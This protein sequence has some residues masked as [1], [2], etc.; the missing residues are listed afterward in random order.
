MTPMESQAAY[1]KFRHA[2][3]YARKILVEKE[4]WFGNPALFNDPFDCSIDF[5]HFVERNR[6][7]FNNPEEIIKFVKDGLHVNQEQENRYI[8]SLNSYRDPAGCYPYEDVVMWSHYGDDH[9]GVCFGFNFK[10]LRSNHNIRRNDVHYDL[11]LFL[12]DLKQ[13]DQQ[14]TDI[15]QTNL[16]PYIQDFKYQLLDYQYFLKA[17][18]W[19]YEQECRYIFDDGFAEDIPPKDGIAV[20]FEPSDLRAV[21]FG[22]HIDKTERETFSRLLQQSDWSHVYIFEV[23]KGHESFEL[24]F[25]LIRDGVKP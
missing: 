7:D 25:E 24:S 1:W 6:S 20:P 17:K 23:K 18:N 21:I 11:N 5:S 8:F 16:A 3:L 12:D 10:S 15:K 13:L 22:L 19:K 9:K 2:D 14:Y 4:V